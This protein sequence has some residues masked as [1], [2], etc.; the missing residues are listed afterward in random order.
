MRFAFDDFL[1]DIDAFRL[2][3]DGTEVDVEPRV[4]ET[5]VFL[6]RERHRVI[7]KE[8]LLETVWEVDFASEATLFKAI[9]QARKALGDD[10]RSQRFIKTV[11]GKGYRFLAEVVEAS[12]TGAPPVVSGP[13]PTVGAPSSPVAPRA[14]NGRRFGAIGAAVGLIAV[15]ALGWMVGRP[16]TTKESSDRL[17]VAVLDCAGDPGLGQDQHWMPEAVPELLFLRL[18]SAGGLRMVAAEEVAA[19]LRDLG[20]DADALNGPKILDRLACDVVI[21]TWLH[22]QAGG[23]L[24][25][26]ATIIWRG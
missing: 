8:E 9:Q 14:G 15:I 10:G 3:R 18:R 4:F 26:E 21:P 7:S 1:L 6:V 22:P 24:G 11:H 17:T 23:G 12:A 16:D 20:G 2:T 13:E 25:L 5:L 19:A